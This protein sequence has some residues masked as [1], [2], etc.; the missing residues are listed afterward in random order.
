MEANK[1]LAL[2]CVAFHA[3]KY[4][5]AGRLFAES[6][7]SESADEVL[8]ALLD[9]TDVEYAVDDLKQLV[10][11]S[12]SF[13]SLSAVVEEL[14]ASMESSD[15][16]QVTAEA[17]CDMDQDDTVSGPEATEPSDEEGS[18]DQEL[19]DTIEPSAEIT[20]DQPIVLPEIV[21]DLPELVDV[22]EVATD[23]VD[24]SEPAI[25]TADQVAV[26]AV[27]SVL[28]FKVD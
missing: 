5:E 4:D 18:Y 11:S 7:R 21:N 26:M 1:L 24:D 8:C 10:E 13:Q 27:A 22:Q 9:K 12:S 20:Q 2:A 14:S 6:M 28:K 16:E 17:D 15:C 19:L 25:P 23:T 3:G